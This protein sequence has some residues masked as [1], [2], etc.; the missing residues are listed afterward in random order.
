MRTQHHDSSP[1]PKTPPTKRAAD[2]EGEHDSL[3]IMTPSQPLH[4]KLE[5]LE[6]RWSEKRPSARHD[7]TQYMFAAGGRILHQPSRPKVP[8]Q[9]LSPAKRTPVR[10]QNVPVEII[11]SPDQLRARRGEKQSVFDRLYRQGQSSSSRKQRPRDGRSFHSMPMPTTPQ[12]SS[13]EGTIST[14]SSSESVFDRLY[15]NEK[16]NRAD[17]PRSS[18]PLSSVA[19]AREVYQSDSM[20]AAASLERRLAYA[21]P[22]VRRRNRVS[23]TGKVTSLIQQHES[24]KS[25]GR[26]SQPGT[27]RSNSSRSPRTPKSKDDR[28]ISSN[29]DSV[30][31]RLYR[32]EKRKSPIMPQRTSTRPT[33]KTR[34]TQASPA[35]SKRRNSPSATDS[36]FDRLY[37][38]EK[39]KTPL[40]AQRK[41]RLQDSRTA[42]TG[43]GRTSHEDDTPS[44]TEESI[45]EESLRDAGDS[46]DSLLL[47]DLP[48][49]TVLSFAKHSSDGRQRELSRSAVGGEKATGL[50]HILGKE[51]GSNSV[52]ETL[53]RLKLQLFVR[54]IQRCARAYIERAPRPDNKYRTRVQFTTDWSEGH[55]NSSV[56]CLQRVWRGYHSRLKTLASLQD[57]CSRVDF[58]FLG[59][60]DYS[61]RM[62]SRIHTQ[63]LAMVMA[64][65][66]NAGLTRIHDDKREINVDW[67]KQ[68]VF[69]FTQNGFAKME[70]VVVSV[71]CSMVRFLFT[72]RWDSRSLSA[73]IVKAVLLDN[74][75]KER[76]RLVDAAIHTIQLWARGM[77]RTGG[78]SWRSGSVLSIKTS[79]LQYLLQYLTPTSLQRRSAITLQ[80]AWRFHQSQVR[81]ADAMLTSWQVFCTFE[82]ETTSNRIL[83]KK[84]VLHAFSKAIGRVDC[85]WIAAPEN[86]RV[87]DRSVVVKWAREVGVHYFSVTGIP[88]LETCTVG[89]DCEGTRNLFVDKWG[90]RKTAILIVKAALKRAILRD[91]SILIEFSAKMVQSWFR[92][93]QMKASYLCRVDACRNTQSPPQLKTVNSDGLANTSQSCDNDADS[94]VI[95]EHAAIVAQSFIR[96]FLLVCRLQRRDEASRT[97]QYF[98]RQKFT[99]RSTQVQKAAAILVIQSSVRSYIR[100]ITNERSNRSAKMIQALWRG[101]TTHDAFRELKKSA[102]VIQKWERRRQCEELYNEHVVASN[103]IQDFYRNTQ[104]QRQAVCA[105]DSATKIQSAY[106]RY[107]AMSSF[108]KISAGIV[109]LQA[110]HRGIMARRLILL[111]HTLVTQSRLALVVQKLWRGNHVRKWYSLLCNAAIAIQSSYRRHYTRDCFLDLRRRAMVLQKWYRRTKSHRTLEAALRLQMAWRRSRCRA[112][113]ASLREMSIRENAATMIQRWHRCHEIRSDFLTL[114]E[115]A[116]EIQAFE[117]RRSSVVKFQRLQSRLIRI[118][119]LFRGGVT[120]REFVLN[121][122]SAQLI[123]AVWRGSRRQRYYETM[124]NSAVLL[125]SS[126]R[127]L[128]A[129]TSFHKVI[130]G[131]SLLQAIYRGQTVRNCSA[132]QSLAATKLQAWW[133]AERARC[134][135]STTLD[136]R[137]KEHMAFY[138]GILQRAFRVRKRRKEAACILI[139]KRYR[140]RLCLES[141]RDLVH[142]VVAIQ[143]AE[144]RRQA[145]ARYNRLVR[146]AVCLQACQRGIVAREDKR[147]FNKV[148]EATIFI[149]KYLRRHFLRQN[150]LEL[151]HIAVR[152][153][154]MERRRQSLANYQHIKR[155][156][157]VLQ[158]FLRGHTTRNF[159]TT[160]NNAA[161]T[162]QRYYR[163]RSLRQNF[164]MLKQVAIQIQTVER[165]RQSLSSYQRI[166]RGCIKLQAHYRGAMTRARLLAKSQAFYSAAVLLQKRWRSYFSREKFRSTKDAALQIQTAERRRRCLL[167]YYAT[168]NGIIHLQACYRGFHARQMLIDRAQAED[169]AAVIIQSHWRRFCSQRKC[170]TFSAMAVRLQAHYR[171]FLIRRLLTE[172][173]AAVIIQSFCRTI[174]P[175]RK[176]LARRQAAVRIQTRERLRRCLQWYSRILNAI[177]LFQARARGLV[178]RRSSDLR[179]KAAVVIQA[180]WRAYLAS[181]RY[182]VL[183][184]G[185]VALQLAVRSRRATYEMHQLI[186]GIILL[187]AKQRGVLVRRDLD[188]QHYAAMR[189]QRAW[190]LRCHQVLIPYVDLADDG[191]LDSSSKPILHGPEHFPARN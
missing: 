83:E 70:T 171:G 163:G 105:N 54:R 162:V 133:R 29:A 139:Q 72:R 53:A 184:T 125:Q 101:T 88:H 91:Q 120:R 141:L 127:S 104:I 151:R 114:R 77:I 152:I 79:G 143:A 135:L 16:R 137:R 121:A 86:V 94:V 115:A 75:A 148:I 165:R 49:P 2:E 166:V 157:V 131:V 159:R 98:V 189:I 37:K 191:S 36:V 92:M 10:K 12:S 32:G 142:A 69:H 42:L 23:S 172:L 6:D 48:A 22:P 108:R 68:A 156:I 46:D 85:L 57:P 64:F 186:R 51:I 102:I 124:R 19:S 1:E 117:R 89:V 17:I 56:V 50:T 20:S 28:S 122:S 119:A 130:V 155:S 112:S 41:R 167:N 150:Y 161:I 145:L 26:N 113:K 81:A 154:C 11:G 180:K 45:L 43:I 153:Q 52:G 30:F 15:K 76:E 39:R 188:E 176:F 13:V 182:H 168:M 103:V 177:T 55:R 147:E 187:Q 160:R 132:K 65:A 3:S 136:N 58:E 149:Q 9:S 93:I 107:I 96:R 27:P 44:R 24:R 129:M 183:S 178:V 73:M 63:T 164:V 5:E 14:L 110:A 38:G 61:D 18:R 118:Q 84:V 146:V 175:R 179:S 67:S 128:N 62:Q 138:V 71:K 190:K 144:R 90:R 158:T 106:R 181:G 116:V 21:A 34:E 87:C 8:S 170:I 59:K 66:G 74:Y 60:N 33:V 7:D 126:I 134:F 97:I 4:D 78:V 40:T 35:Q 80:N 123:Q 169:L 99:R 174:V 173:S 95:Q 185:V 82:S 31:D 109:A 100:E 47:D 140:S 25:S 111:W